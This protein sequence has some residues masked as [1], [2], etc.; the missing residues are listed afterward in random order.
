[1]KSHKPIHAIIPGLGQRSLKTAFAAAIL[2]LIYHPFGGDPTFACIGVIF[3]MGNGM[4]DSKISGGNRLI[5]TI[6]GGLLGLGIYWVEHWVFPSGNYYLKVALIFFGLILLV[7][8]SVTFKWPGAVQPGGV[9]LC[10]I[11][12]NTPTNY[13]AYA[14]GRMFD[15]AIGVI[16]AIAVNELLKRNRIDRWLK[17]EVREEM[18]EETRE[19]D[20]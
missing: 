4:E 6:I 12:F 18:R 8:S 3:G 11:L 16:F 20:V 2:A 5:G 17:R 14:F 9:V 15:T 7:C 10:I 13:T 19:L 1:M